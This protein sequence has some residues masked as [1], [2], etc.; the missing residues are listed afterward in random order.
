MEQ[1]KLKL[2]IP[3]DEAALAPIQKYRAPER[4]SV[5]PGRVAV[6]LVALA[7]A[8]LARKLFGTD[9]AQAEGVQDGPAHPRQIPTPPPARRRRTRIT[10]PKWGR[11]RHWRKRR[12]SPIPCPTT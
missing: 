10:S 8:A 5:W 1:D 11:A 3:D 7:W 6:G 9:A 4:R 12:S 2:G